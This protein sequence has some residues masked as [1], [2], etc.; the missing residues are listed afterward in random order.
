[1]LTHYKTRHRPHFF[2][3]RF[4]YTPQYNNYAIPSPSILH[5][6]QFCIED[7][8]SNIL[9]SVEN[10]PHRS[11]I[12]TTV[13]LLFSTRPTR[14]PQHIHPFFEP[15]HP[16][17]PS[18]STRLTNLHCHSC[19]FCS[20]FWEFSFLS[21]NPT[22][23]P[24]WLFWPISINLPLSHYSIFHHSPPNYWYIY[25]TVYGTNSHYSC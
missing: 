2:L 1:M 19:C 5:R 25:N 10:T 22:Y 23:K 3:L 20:D 6:H 17:S 7:A 24:F 14:Q 12:T 16:P 21:Q 9:L 8:I 18:C 4:L 11:V 13:I 15:A